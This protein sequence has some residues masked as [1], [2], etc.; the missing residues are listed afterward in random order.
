MRSSCHRADTM[1]VAS[2]LAFV[3]KPGQSP[4]TVKHEACL[5]VCVCVWEFPVSVS[6]PPAAGVAPCGGL[7]P[8]MAT[9]P[10]TQASL[11]TWRLEPAPNVRLSAQQGAPR[12]M[13]WAGR[14]QQLPPARTETH[15]APLRPPPGHTPTLTSTEHKVT[16]ASSDHCYARPASSRSAPPAARHRLEAPRACASRIVTPQR[17]PRGIH[18]P[19]RFDS[20]QSLPKS[21]NGLEAELGGPG[22]I[23]GGRVGTSSLGLRVEMANDYTFFCDLPCSE[24]LGT[25]GPRAATGFV[26][27]SAVPDLYGITTTHV[28]RST[29]R[30]LQKRSAVQSGGGS[31]PKGF[32]EKTLCEA[33]KT[34]ARKFTPETM[35][36]NTSRTR[37]GAT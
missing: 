32:C 2:K 5:V 13:R 29:L 18:L 28:V 25:I 37:G 21:K 1:L 17:H 7:P 9:R 12:R 19:P 27:S 6:S 30:S 24:R 15:S 4:T 22:P 26:L 3:P 8:H 36:Q 14:R 35:L 11:S 10:R 20:G 34:A 23:R 31:G 33:K 16:R